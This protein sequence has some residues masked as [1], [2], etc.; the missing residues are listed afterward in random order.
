MYQ[1][2]WN[3]VVLA[4][5]EQTIRVEGNHYFPPQSL[6]SAYFA[7]T[8]LTSQCA[9]KG[10]ATYYTLTVD[11]QKN[12]NAAWKYPNPTPAAEKIR[13]YVAFSNGVRVVKVQQ[14]GERREN[15]FVAL[16]RR[17]MPGK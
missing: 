3:D 13:D 11:G 17:I 1:A 7:D 15:A 9:W 16:C 5:S 2:V 8:S 12:T 4:E 6:N 14:D 10:T